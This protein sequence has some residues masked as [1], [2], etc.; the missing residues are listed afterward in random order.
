MCASK[1]VGRER[2]KKN[3]KLV[4]VGIGCI[5][6]L[7]AIAL[8]KGMNGTLLTIVVGTI[9]A[10]IGVIIPTPKWLKKV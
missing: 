7:E 10:A 2:M 9:A 4:I 8:F 3:H 6:L 1:M 5:T